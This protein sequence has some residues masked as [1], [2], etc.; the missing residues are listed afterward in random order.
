[1][2]VS[3]S[4]DGENIN[5]LWGFLLIEELV[6]NGIDYFCISPGSRSAPLTVAAARH[7]G[8]HKIIGHDE[9][10]AAFHALGYARA[11][12]RP[13]VLI[14]TSGTA[15]ANY[16][17]AVIEAALDRLPLLILSADR[18]PEAQDT[19]ANQTIRQSHLFGTYAKWHFELPCPSTDVPARMV[20]T[21]VNQAIHQSWTAP[22]G[23]VH[24]NC[25]FREPLAPEP[26]GIDA[27]YLANLTRWQETA[28]PLTQYHRPIRTPDAL[29]VR[30]LSAVLRAARRGLVVVGRLSTD[31]E[32]SALIRLLQRLRWPVY[33]D[34][35]SGLRLGSVDAPIVHHFDQ[36]L[37]SPMAGA[38]LHPDTILH[39]GGALVSRRFL[40][41]SEHLP[42][43]VHYLLIDAHPFRHDPGHRVSQRMEAD[44]VAACVALLATLEAREPSAWTQA[45][46]AYSEAIDAAINDSLATTPDCL[47]EIAVARLIAE[48][49]PARQGL[50]LASSMPIRDMDMYGKPRGRTV[51]IGAN[52]GTSGIDGTVAAATGFAAGLRQPVTLLL[53][54]VALLHD[55]NSLL[56]VRNSAVPLIVVVIN[57]D[58]GGIFSFLPIAR[59]DDV[60][61][62]YFASPHA[63]RFESAAALFALGYAAPRTQA[64]FVAAYEAALARPG[65]TLIEV[66]SDRQANT[67]GHQQ[68]QRH[69][70]ATL[71]NLW[72]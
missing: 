52:R 56:L 37:L 22:P 24:L 67:A 65:S 64:E 31:R 51:R 43:A 21:T 68:L 19:G 9:R 47:S 46:L 66:V 45:L 44:I 39:V 72:H 50:W 35:T 6:R 32:R 20:L 62:H 27:A 29:A 15:A 59:F 40:Q 26:L 57:N 48:R 63:L 38:S 33:A 71:A 42:E 4:L 30:T 53:G 54:D 58:G 8:A 41:F 14:C 17:P 34:I 3:R 23:P 49:I 7:P 16:W 1:M 70:A 2:P 11:T 18:P 55:L 36:L 61:E 10:G 69:I 28:T 12:G 5:S 13:A 25:P 60:F